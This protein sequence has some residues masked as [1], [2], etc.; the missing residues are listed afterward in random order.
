M[1][2]IIIWPGIIAAIYLACG[3]FVFFSACTFGWGMNWVP[4]WLREI[5]WIV[6]CPVVYLI[7]FV[8]HIMGKNFR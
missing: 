3:A 5:I 6:F 8:C 7:A 4:T 2:E 1:I